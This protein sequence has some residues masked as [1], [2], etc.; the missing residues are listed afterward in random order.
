MSLFL[1][2]F[3]ITFCGEI[4]LCNREG[5]YA[6]GR[7]LVRGRPFPMLKFEFIFQIKYTK[8]AFLSDSTRKLL[9]L[10]FTKILI[11]V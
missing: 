2:F 8:A 5:K 6:I 4:K 1:F 9:L 11:A 10:E 3:A 7:V